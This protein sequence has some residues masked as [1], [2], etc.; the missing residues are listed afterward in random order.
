MWILQKES[1]G[2]VKQKLARRRKYEQYRLYNE[3][4]A[5]ERRAAEREAA[6]AAR[7]EAAGA[8]GGLRE[9]MGAKA[10]ALLE[11]TK[12][13][14]VEKAEAYAKFVEERQALL[15]K[16]LPPPPEPVDAAPAKGKKK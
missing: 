3:R 8:R 15:E 11:A 4:L 16:L 12:A 10:A 14:R 2:N 5:E 9:A 7:E 6:M 1:F 13:Q